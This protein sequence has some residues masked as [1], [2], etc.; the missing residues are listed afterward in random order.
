MNSVLGGRIPSK[1]IVSFIW[2][3][4]QPPSEEKPSSFCLE[5]AFW[6]H[7][8]EIFSDGF[9][10]SH[11]STCMQAF[12]IHFWTSRCFHW[13]GW[14]VGCI[15]SL[16]TDHTP[17][18]NWTCWRIYHWISSWG[19][20]ILLFRY[21]HWFAFKKRFLRIKEET[22]G[23]FVHWFALTFY[24]ETLLPCIILLRFL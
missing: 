1:G 23:Q 16:C 14:V 6:K 20:W 21:P 13:D 11:L 8:E 24:T 17:A 2:E 9:V 10:F 5:D 18:L 3:V 12:G 19:W 7:P 15:A 22:D 4:I